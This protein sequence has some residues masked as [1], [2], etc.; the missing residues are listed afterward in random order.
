[1]GGVRRRRC[2]TLL[3]TAFLFRRSSGQP[4][5]RDERGGGLRWAW[6]VARVRVVVDGNVL[7]RRFN[8]HMPLESIIFP[9]FPSSYCLVIWAHA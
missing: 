9:F 2:R 7:S 4:A 3:M 1:M 5:T 8:F 6:S